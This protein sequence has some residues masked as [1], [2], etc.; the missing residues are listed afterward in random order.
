MH[1]IWRNEAHHLHQSINLPGLP[2]KSIRKKAKKKTVLTAATLLFYNMQRTD[3][4]PLT[5]SYRVRSKCNHEKPLEATGL[6]I[7]D[8]AYLCGGILTSHP[9]P[10]PQLSWQPSMRWIKHNSISLF[11]ISRAK[12]VPAAVA[13]L[14]RAAT[15]PSSKWELCFLYIKD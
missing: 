9:S 5:S 11:G 6:R 15:S 14:K 12:K 7:M 8:C 4:L 2:E 13:H 10:L 3:V 1:R